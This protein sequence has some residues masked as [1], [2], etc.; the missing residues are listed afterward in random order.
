MSRPKRDE[1]GA[2]HDRLF[3]PML[4]RAVL[5]WLARLVLQPH[6]RPICGC[7]RAD[8]RGFLDDFDAYSR[9]SDQVRL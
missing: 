5:R 1:G 3:C 8:G 2:A 9:T 6:L 7:R 4:M